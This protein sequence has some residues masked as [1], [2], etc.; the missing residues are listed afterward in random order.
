[1]TPAPVNPADLRAVATLIVAEAALDRDPATIIEDDLIDDLGLDSFD[2][3]GLVCRIEDSF[4]IEIAF[5][6]EE[7]WAS[8]GDICRAIDRARAY[9]RG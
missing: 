6:E 1:M 4:A 8:V 2:R 7:Q 3:A 5:T 9:S